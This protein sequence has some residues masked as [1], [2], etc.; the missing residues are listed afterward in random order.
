MEWLCFSL[1]FPPNITNVRRDLELYRKLR[2]AG[3]KMGASLS[4][5]N[6]WKF[7]TQTCC[8]KF[9]PPTSPGTSSEPSL[10]P[11]P[12]SPTARPSPHLYH[13]VPLFLDFTLRGWVREQ[14]G[15]PYL[16][17][18]KVCHFPNK[19]SCLSA[20]NWHLSLE[21]KPA[22]DTHSIGNNLR[23]SDYSYAGR[24]RA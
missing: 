20:S 21:R 7:K 14:A 6:S 4:P 2:V 23:Y 17:H 1:N 12:S 13:F 3:E 18:S 10:Q 19:D 5:A 9:H 8:C 22:R 11:L 24:N 16:S 15:G